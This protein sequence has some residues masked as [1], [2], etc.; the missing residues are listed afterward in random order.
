[1]YGHC[2][3]GTTL[4]VT[5]KSF[6]R[7]PGKIGPQRKTCALHCGRFLSGLLSG[8]NSAIAGARSRAHQPAESH[9]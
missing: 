7:V 9:A 3:R 4:A 8:Y 1:M 2:K 5:V 6:A